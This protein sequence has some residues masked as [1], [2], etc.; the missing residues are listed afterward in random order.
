MNFAFSFLKRWAALL[1]CAGVLSF[2]TATGCEL[3]VDGGLTLTMRAAK[4]ND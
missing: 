3:L 4:S 2:A 1:A